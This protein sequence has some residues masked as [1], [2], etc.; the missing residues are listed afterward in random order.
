MNGKT[1][2]GQGLEDLI[3]LRWQHPPKWIY[4]FSTISIKIPDG[5]FV[6]NLQADPKIRMELQGTQ[7][8]Q[9]SLEKEEQSGGLLHH[10]FKTYNKST[11]ILIVW[12]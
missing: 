4:R 6:K 7:N 12:Y 2:H 8:S 9:N 5:F 10:D 3:L 11:V 1:S